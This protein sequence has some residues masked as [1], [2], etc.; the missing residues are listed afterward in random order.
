MFLLFTTFLF[1]SQSISAV[2]VRNTTTNDLDFIRTSCNAT[3]YPDL[4]VTSLS[5]YASAVHKSPAKLAKLAI[6]VSMSEAKSTAGFLSKLTKSAVA[7][8]AKHSQGEITRA[9]IRD[10]VSNV[11]EAID[12]M[13]DSLRQLGNKNGT[14]D[15]VTVGG[16]VETFRCQMNNVQTYM[17]A[18]MTMEETCTDGFDEMQK[19]V[20][21]INT[22]VRPRVEQVKRVT[23]NALALVVAYANGGP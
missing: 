4:C 9:A 13:R 20:R 6:R 23:S 15:G 5:R 19:P 18:A 3:E 2:H 8:T 10:C 22:T 7:V 16:P 1:I 14:C 21:I 17:T 12:Y 11:E